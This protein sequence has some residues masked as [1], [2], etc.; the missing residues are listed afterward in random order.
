MNEGAILETQRLSL[1]KLNLKDADFILRLVNTPPWL[2]FIGD[3]NVK[4]I[5]DARNYLETG[6]LK[7]YEANGF[8]LWLVELK[9]SNAPIGICGLINRDALE[10]IDIGFAI[11]PEFFQLGYGYEMA[12]ATMGY[13]KNIL[14]IDKVI[15]IVSLNNLASM[16]LLNKMGLYFDRNI[17]L[18]PGDPVQVFSESNENLK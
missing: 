10:D 7:S 5:D 6:P 15:A 9:E 12:N 11:L 17:E 18:V 14:K 13:A 3:K 8:G 2:A 16:K 1:R 4:S